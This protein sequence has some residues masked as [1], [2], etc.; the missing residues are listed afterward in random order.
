MH[1][2]TNIS[3]A[4]ADPTVR[5]LVSVLI[6]KILFQLLISEALHRQC[7]ASHVLQLSQFFFWL[8]IETQQEKE[9]C[10]RMADFPT[11]AENTAISHL[12]TL[13]KMLEVHCYLYLF[14]FDIPQENNSSRSLRG[15][16]AF[17][18]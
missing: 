17:L 4:K 8:V 14:S 13:K 11:V 16:Q 10:L 18:L 12:K 3:L 6:V 7:Y 15:K 5:I 9:A 1:V 2:S